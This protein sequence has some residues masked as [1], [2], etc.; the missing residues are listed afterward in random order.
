MAEAMNEFQAALRISPNDPDTETNIG[1]ALLQ[2]GDAEES[3][4]HLRKVVE[5]FPRHAPAHINL[6]NA[7]LQTGQTDAAVAEY[8]QTLDLPFDHAESHYSIANAFRKKGD[9]EAA[10]AHYRKALENRPDFANAHN[11]LGNALRQ[12]GKIQQAMHEY[13]AALKNDPE[14]FLAANNLAWM[15]ATSSDPSIRNG[16]KAVQLAEQ[17]NDQ[18]GGDPL[19]LHTLAA[20]YAE[21]GQFP[22]AVEVAQHALEI[23]EANGITSLAESLRN[24]LALYQ[25]GT[26]YHET[27]P[28]R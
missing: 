3:I 16:A 2:E 26:P 17:A 12:Q 20:A 11:N 21:N 9:V 6:G 23:A 25:A 1:A 13:E 18:S 10:I 5:K 4:S 22:K 28:S 8:K 14:L 19:I 24:K 27:V 7:L 15:L